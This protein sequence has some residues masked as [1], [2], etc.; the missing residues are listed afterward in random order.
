MPLLEKNIEN[1]MKELS[2]LY[3]QIL[4]F[5]DRDTDVTSEEVS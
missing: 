3:E 4:N 1:R 2:I 5:N